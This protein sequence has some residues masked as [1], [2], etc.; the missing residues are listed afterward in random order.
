[1]SA[2]PACPGCGLAS[3]APGIQPDREVHASAACWGLHAEL[4][5]FELLHAARLGRLHQLTVDAYG[6]QHPDPDGTGL[7]LAYSLVGLCLALER[8]W[9]G[10]EVREMHAR[11]GRWQSWWPAFHR[12]APVVPSIEPKRRRAPAG[13]PDPAGAPA[14]E[15]TVADV[16]RVG[17]RADSV[18]GHAGAVEAWADGVWARWGP[19]HV[20]IRAFTDRVLA[21]RR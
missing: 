4:V 13:D 1:M 20:T 14:P 7:R 15:P 16:V 18:E 11:M 8:G 19:E 10:L 12:P 3:D 21:V 9:T 17:V 6:A 5:G 2:G